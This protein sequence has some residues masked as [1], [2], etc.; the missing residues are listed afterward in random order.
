MDSAT[1][2]KR[3][4]RK[5]KK[6]SQA[7]RYAMR[8]VSGR[9]RPAAGGQ[10]CQKHHQT[11]GEQRFGDPGCS[12]CRAGKA[13]NS[14]DDGDDQKCNGSSEHGVLLSGL[15][16]AREGGIRLLQGMCQMN[17]LLLNQAP[18][19]PVPVPGRASGSP[20]SPAP[21]VQPVSSRSWN[22]AGLRPWRCSSRYT[23]VRLRPAS[24]ATSLTWPCVSFRS[25]TR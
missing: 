5:P 4:G 21:D 17:D 1:S 24:R 25:V 19:V 18:G 23:S 13:E 7:P 8:H 6:G 14:G 15:M 20:L 10:Q 22:R 2:G 9:R 11:D 3:A 12:A 16:K